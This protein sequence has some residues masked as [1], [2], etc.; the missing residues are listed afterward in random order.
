MN[1]KILGL[2]SKPFEHLYGMPDQ[3]LKARGI[4][5]RVVDQSSAFP[6][7]IEMRDCD[8]GETVLLLNHLYQPCNSP[9]RASHAIYIREG[10]TKSFEAINR[11]PK[12]L[13]SRLQALR[14]FDADGMMVDA[15]I[16]DGTAMEPVI[17]AMF[18]NPNVRYI[19][20]HNA[21]RGCYAGRIERA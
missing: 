11:I 4:I 3:A 20:T 5:R 10:A 19:Q 17:E 16:V 18:A 2:S 9:Y 21:K 14:G 1:Y 15:E 13:T 7:R 8:P 6:D 12:V